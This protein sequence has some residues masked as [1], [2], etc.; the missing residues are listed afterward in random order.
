MPGLVERRHDDL[1]MITLF[2]KQIKTIMSV[3]HCLQGINRLPVVRRT[4]LPNGVPWKGQEQHRIGG[5]VKK[6]STPPIPYLEADGEAD[7]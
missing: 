1:K 3:A 5:G 7:S 4:T 2:G 6:V